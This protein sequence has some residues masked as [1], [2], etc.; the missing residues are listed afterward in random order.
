MNPGVI[1]ACIP[2][3][4]L[5]IPIVAII[6]S[7]VQKLAKLRIEEAKARAG[8]LDEGTGAEVQALREEVTALHGE[9]EELNERMDFAERVLAQ[10]RDK[11]RLPGPTEISPS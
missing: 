4:V 9:L 8:S 1:G 6:S 11:G 7:G 2:M 10:V 5:A 3:F